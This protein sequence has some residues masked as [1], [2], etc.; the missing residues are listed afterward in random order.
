KSMRGE[1]V[2]EAELTEYGLLGDRAYAL[3]DNAE[4]KAATAKNPGKWPTL[5]GCR[6]TFVDQPKKRAPLP[7]VRI[8]LHDG[9]TL[10]SSAR[11]CH[12]ILSKVLNRR[13]TLATA[14]RGCVNGV[15]TSLPPNP[16]AK[17][18]HSHPP[19]TRPRPP[20]PPPS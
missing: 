14:D 17:P 3:I 13:V 19:L 4:G 1:E 15:P 8:T 10:M 20:A 16:P 5:F 11:D 12:Q 18:P 6:A 2:S 7:A 9:T